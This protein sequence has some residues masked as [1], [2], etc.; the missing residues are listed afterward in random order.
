MYLAI[1]LVLIATLANCAASLKKVEV[2]KGDGMLIQSVDDVVALFPK[3][4]E[5]IEER[6]QKLQA[7]TLEDLRTII[8]IDPGARTF[9]NTARALDHVMGHFA[10]ESEALG[11]LEHVSPDEALRTA[12]HE[13]SSYLQ[14]FAIDAFSSSMDLYQAVKAYVE[15]NANQETLRDEERYFLAEVMLEFRRNGLDLAPTKLEKVKKISKEIAVLSRQFE[16][17]IAE[18][19]R[20]IV[21]TLSELSGL[22]EEF[23]NALRKTEAGGCVLG[24]DYPTYT[25]VM[26]NCSNEG[27]R[28]KLFLSFGQRA[29]PENIAVLNELIAKRD[30]FAKLLGYPSY[31]AYDIDNQMAHTVETVQNFLSNVATKA[32]IKDEAEFREFTKQLPESVELTDD[33]LLKPWDRAYLIAQYKKHH[34]NLEERQLA[35]YFPAD[36]TIKGLMHIYEQFMSLRMEEV[37]VPGLWHEDLKMLAIYDKTNTLRG[38]LILDLYP[39]PCKYSH[40]ASWSILPTTKCRTKAMEV[41][42]TTFEG[43]HHPSVAVDVVVCNFPKGTKARPALLKHRDVETFF[44]E[45]GHA[46]HTILGTT[47]LAYFSGTRTKLDFVE[48]PSQM[49][50]EWMWDKNILHMLSRNYKTGDKMPDDLI[51]KKIELK[52][53]DMGGQILR[54]VGLAE[55]SLGLYSEGAKKDIPALQKKLHAQY[56]PN[57]LFEPNEYMYASFGHLS[58]YGARYYSYLWSKVFALDVFAEIKKQGLLNPAIGSRYVDEILSK[59]GSIDP[60]QLLKSFLGRAPNDKAFFHELGL[61]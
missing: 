19:Q 54:Q 5:E 55:L 27:T 48:L 43:D 18:G 42:T 24:T 30:E 33:G 11:M 2:E 53:L 40:A 3:T 26:E 20:E 50:E 35:E 47:E 14:Q 21:V 38:Y 28:K 52:N 34:Y 39:R 12:S 61:N 23:I 25:A 1:S 46:I 9:E 16:K 22:D 51:E 59:G 13:A 45:F 29:Y 44:H 60:N 57:M 8:N 6:K 41:V 49:L 31:A 56:R 4:I 37:P 15:G 7:K 17:N 32:R 10:I 58:G 36:H